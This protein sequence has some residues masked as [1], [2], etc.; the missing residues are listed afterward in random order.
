MGTNP[1]ILLAEDHEDTRGVYSLILRHFGFNVLEA[2]NGIA[3]VNIARETRP[4]LVLMDIGLPGLDGWEASRLLK[5]TPA[6]A[7]IPLIAFSGRI[8]ST[9]DLGAAATFDGFILKPI[10]PLELVRRI[11]A[12]VGLLSSRRSDGHGVRRVESRSSG[13]SEIAI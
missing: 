8:I 11:Q 9:A 2:T 5:S 10:S 6:T 4:G 3:A 1:I 12:Y 7:S 13:P